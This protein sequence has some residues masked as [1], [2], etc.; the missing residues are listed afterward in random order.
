MRT[1]RLLLFLVTYSKNIVNLLLYYSATQNEN[2]LLSSFFV[3]TL[4]YAGLYLQYKLTPKR[5]H[6]RLYRVT[7][8]TALFSRYAVYRIGYS[9]DDLRGVDGQEN[10]CPQVAYISDLIR[11]SSHVFQLAEQWLPERNNT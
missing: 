4:L 6:E 10:A 5:K 3:L 2:L 11:I 9:S 1:D 7:D 8:R